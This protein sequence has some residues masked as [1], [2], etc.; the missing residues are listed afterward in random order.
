MIIKSDPEDP[1]ICHIVKEVYKGLVEFNDEEDLK[2]SYLLLKPEEDEKV[3]WIIRSTYNICN[4]ESELFWKMSKKIYDFE[5]NRYHYYDIA[6]NREEKRKLIKEEDFRP[7]LEE[8][9]QPLY[10]EVER[11]FANP[12]PQDIEK[13]INI[14]PD[15]VY[16]VYQNIYKE[17]L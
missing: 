10:K 7:Y 16:G 13:I 4:K 2:N 14:L 11:Y 5:Y 3:V 8:W 9:K 6:T 15:S 17:E 12:T 1:D